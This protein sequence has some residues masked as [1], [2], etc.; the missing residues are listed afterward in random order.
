VWSSKYTVCQW[1][2]V[3]RWFSPSTSISPTNK[4]DHHDITEILLK[5]ALN[6]LI[7]TS[8]PLNIQLN[9]LSRTL[10]N[11]TLDTSNVKGYSFVIVFTLTL[12]HIVQ[13]LGYFNCAVYKIRIFF[14]HKYGSLYCG[15]FLADTCR[16]R[17]WIYNCCTCQHSWN[18]A[19]FGDKL[20]SIYQQKNKK[21]GTWV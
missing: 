12:S 2:V 3:G 10:I 6:T 11:L 4:T 9:L 20:K 5:M 18:I 8:N 13:Q 17:I 16:Y 21:T 1:L 7:L 14:Y 19:E 15:L